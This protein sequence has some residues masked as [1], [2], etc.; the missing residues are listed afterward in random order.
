M[1]ELISV[2]VPIYNVEKYLERCIKSIINQT[3]EKIE[4]ILVDDG[5]TDK[6][7]KI[8]DDYKK[9][10]TRIKV[11]HKKNG[12]LSDDRNAGLKIAKGKYITFID[13]DDF[14]DKTFIKTLY[15]MCKENNAQISQCKFRKV[16]YENFN[17]KQE[18]EEAKIE[19]IIKT[20]KEMFYD[21]YTGN[22]MIYI[23]AWNKLYKKSLFKGIEY[24]KGKINEDEATTYKLFYK[25]KK[26]AI[27][28]QVL[29]NDVYR[30]NSIMNQK[31]NIKRLDS[32]WALEERIK[33]LKEKNEKQ[34]LQLTEIFYAKELMRNYAKVKKYIEN[35]KDIQKDLLKKHRKMSVKLLKE[36]IKI[37]QKLIFIYQIILPDIYSKNYIKRLEK[38]RGENK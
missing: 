8:C 34:L 33:F 3:Y 6:S 35:S 30:K 27:T 10:D 36:N 28:N 22:H 11:I 1:K 21:I 15:E 25:A 2:V 32:L 38:I 31:Y 19:T 9:M 29:Y 12:G 37:K 13:S 4:I 18:S 20:G 7:G 16:G 23:V 5:A 24:P 17:I 14:I 26:V